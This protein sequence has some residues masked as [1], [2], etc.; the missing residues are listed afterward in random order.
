[1]LYESSEM[2]EQ[3]RYQRN[4]FKLHVQARLCFV[5]TYENIWNS[6][7]HAETPRVTLP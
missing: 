3:T 6:I 1:M 5:V 2:I 4:K 7:K